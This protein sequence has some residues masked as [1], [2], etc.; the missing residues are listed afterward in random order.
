MERII[1]ATMM[2]DLEIVFENRRNEKNTHKICN[3]MLDYNEIW[4]QIKWNKKELIHSSDK[5]YYL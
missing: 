1:A 3:F 5:Y 2:R 4:E